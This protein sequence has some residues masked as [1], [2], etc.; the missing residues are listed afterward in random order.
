MPRWGA[1]VV[2]QDLLPGDVP[3]AVGMLLEE[4]Q[5]QQLLGKGDRGIRRPC[6]QQQLLGIQ[7]PT[8]IGI[9]LPQHLLQLPEIYLHTAH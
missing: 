6:R 2:D 1:R 7:H 5:E 9:Q 4:G 3:V 8:A